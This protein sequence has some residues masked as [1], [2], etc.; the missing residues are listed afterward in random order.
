[1][2]YHSNKAREKFLQR[3]YGVQLGRRY[4]LA[5]ASVMLIS[6]LGCSQINSSSERAIA[7]S[8]LP[9]TE[10]VPRINQVMNPDPKI[11]AANTNFGFKIFGEV[12]KQD[13]NKNIFV[14]PYSVSMAL[15]MTYNG[16]SGSTQQKMAQAL[17]L[18][19][20]SLEQ[21]NSA[22]AELSQLLTDPDRQVKLTIANSLWGNQ[23]I[24]FNPDFLQRNRDFYH[25]K[26]TNLN[27]AAS[28]AANQIN[29]WVKDHTQGKIEQIVGQISPDQALF[30]S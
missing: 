11:V 15:A 1:M 5:A 23:N 12:L 3:R 7:E 2:K 28:N 26:V 6:V 14:S 13:K 9:R 25:A 18:Q 8:P 17:D 16:A 29:D 20:L 30:F 27:F 19:G 22:N 4:A 10:E 24:Q 21:I